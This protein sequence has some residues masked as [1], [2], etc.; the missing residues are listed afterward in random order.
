MSFEAEPN[1]DR[2]QPAALTLESSRYLGISRNDDKI[3][4]S[5]SEAP[6][7]A[8]MDPL[9]ASASVLTILGAAGGTCKIL[10]DLI[11]DFKDA[12]EDMKWQNRKLQRLQENLICLLKTCDKLPNELQ[13]ATHFDGMLEFVQQI[14]VI[15]V[16]IERRTTS[17]S[18]GKTARVKEIGKWLLQDRHLK[19]FFDNLEHYNTILSHAI[20]AAQ[21]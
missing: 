2:L 10:Y 6:L 16:D 18:R 9:S 5:S 15:N 7:A 3:L 11:V 12:P 17:L 8:H 14:N 1:G 13:L 21:L 4:A 19:R 20:S